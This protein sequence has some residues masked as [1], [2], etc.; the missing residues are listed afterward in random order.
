MGRSPAGEIVAFYADA[1]TGIV[2]GG[3]IGFARALGDFGITMMVAGDMPGH[4]QTASLYIYDEAVAGRDGSAAIM[5]LVTTIFA[6]VILYAVNVL[7]RRRL[8]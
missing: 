5:S 1:S 4:T 3:M 7:T 8:G 2:A 6:V